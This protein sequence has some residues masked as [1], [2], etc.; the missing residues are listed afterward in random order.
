VDITSVLVDL[1]H[2]RDNIKQAIL[3]LENISDLRPRRRG[4]PRTNFH[5]K[6]GLNAEAVSTSFRPKTMAIAN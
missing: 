1:R 3:A 5:T 4:R 6:T 2:Q